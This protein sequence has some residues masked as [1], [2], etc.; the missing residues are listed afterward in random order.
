VKDFLYHIKVGDVKKQKPDKN[1]S[2][3]IFNDCIERL[4]LCKSLSSKIKP[5]YILE[6]A[7][8]S[9]R[10][11]AYALLYQDGYNPS[12]E[13]AAISYLKTKGFSESELISFD[14]FR[15]I[16][17]GIRHYGRTCDIEDSKEALELAEKVVGKIKGMLR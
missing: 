3:A 10:Q 5:K 16:R 13:K 17:N 9:M 12:S 7:Y 14:R 6:N 1:L 2:N 15:K 8:G 4:K 11:A